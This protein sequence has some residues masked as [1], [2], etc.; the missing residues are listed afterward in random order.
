MVSLHSN[1]N[2]KAGA[3]SPSIE[4]PMDMANGKYI[5]IVHVQNDDFALHL[6]RSA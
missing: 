1:G 6:A 2:S 5:P 4:D 3:T